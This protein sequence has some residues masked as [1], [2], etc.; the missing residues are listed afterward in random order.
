MVQPIVRTHI[1]YHPRFR[2]LGYMKDG[3]GQVTTARSAVE[4]GERLSLNPVQFQTVSPPVILPKI[5]T[6]Q[7]HMARAFH[8]MGTLSPA[9]EEKIRERARYK[10]AHYHLALP[11]DFLVKLAE[12]L[13][14]MMTQAQ[15]LTGKAEDLTQ[16]SLYRD[17]IRTRKL[18][19]ELG[20]LH[21]IET[22]F[23]KQYNLSNYAVTQHITRPPIESSD[24]KAYL[25][26]YLTEDRD[27]SNFR[28][29]FIQ[30]AV[31]NILEVMIEQTVHDPT[32]PKDGAFYRSRFL[33]TEGF[34]GIRLAH[35]TENRLVSGRYKPSLLARIPGIRALFAP[36]A[37]YREQKVQKRLSKGTPY[38]RDVDRLFSHIATRYEIPVKDL[39]RRVA[40]R[41][42]YLIDCAARDINRQNRDSPASERSER[43][44]QAVRNLQPQPKQT[45]R[46][47][48]PSSPQEQLL[49]LAL[50]DLL[51]FYRLKQPESKTV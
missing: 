47:C 18:L 25:M 41:V 31:P 11:E 46:P 2:S 8:F 48:S 43:I 21:S 39:S 13:A 40:H 27:H 12:T 1:V 14:Q 16:K 35:Y 17:N 23:E 37:S 29:G 10:F 32:V 50:Q 42:E 30:Y 38:P 44:R 34:T 36:L 49:Y 33:E 7:E 3:K 19:P 9:Q 28:R 6:R 26:A 45:A 24:W 4:I 51:A 15:V 5:G 20:I 22:G